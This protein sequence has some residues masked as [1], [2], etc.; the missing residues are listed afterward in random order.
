MRTFLKSL[1]GAVTGAVAGL[2]IATSAQAADWTPPGP[3]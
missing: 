2:A 3:I 1:A